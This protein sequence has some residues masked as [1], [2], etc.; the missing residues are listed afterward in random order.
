MISI[1]ESVEALEKCYQEKTLA[2]EC[3]LAA[4][5][6]LAHYTVD[7]DDEITSAQRRYLEAL[8]TE[9][10]PGTP[11]K[12]AESRATLRGL[13]R[14]YRDKSARYLNNLREEL[15]STAAAL[16][17]IMDTLSTSD[18]DHENRVRKTVN[19]LREIS[20]VSDAARVS[21]AIAASADTI[22]Q[23]VEQMKKQHQLAIS[24][25]QVEIRMLHKRIDA[26]ES[27]TMLDQFSK[28]DT[29][30]QIEDHIRT[31]PS[32]YC[33][34]LIR[35]VGF[36]RAETMFDASVSAELAAAFAKRL[37]NCLIPGATIGTWSRE[38]FVAL[39]PVTTAEAMTSAKW[40]G[41]HIS[42]SYACLLNGKTVRPTIQ[43]TV[44]V[45]ETAGSAPDQILKR[46]NA[47]LT[48]G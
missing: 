12:L 35:V 6:N 27:A 2:V 1:R 42:G 23:S 48:G 36:R 30:E 21:A 34:M 3:Y 17:D 18:G 46:I 47:F 43:L 20:R 37:R 11:D 26:L 39:V 29:R 9:V 25:F 44:A 45:V 38:E 10:A 41:E 32:G 33:I 14:D 5:K 7:M 19:R 24:Q 28:L 15:A 4:I 40:I 16:Q 22:E 8:A 31:E 13:L